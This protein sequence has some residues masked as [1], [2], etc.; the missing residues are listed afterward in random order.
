MIFESTFKG[1]TGYYKGG[2]KWWQ[3]NSLTKSLKTSG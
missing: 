3:E 1:G 2:I